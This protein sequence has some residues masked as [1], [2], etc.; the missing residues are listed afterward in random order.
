MERLL[1]ED[2]SV[3]AA[4]LGATTGDALGHQRLADAVTRHLDALPPASVLAL[5]GSWG[6][7]KSD[8]LGRVFACFDQRAK[9]FNTPQP[10]RLDPWQYGTPDLIRPVVLAL[11]NQ[12]SAEDWRGKEKLRIAARTLI[13]AGNAMLFKAL[14]VVVPTPVG[15]IIGAAEQ[16][17][18]DGLDALFSGEP[19]QRPVDPDPVKVMGERFHELV[20]IYV[21]R[22]D[23]RWPLLICVDDL[24][25]CLP[26]HQI[27]MLEAIFFLTA[28]G[29]DCSFLIAL[30][31]MLVQQAAVTHY[32]TAGFDANKY[33]DKL[34][35]LRLSL[36]ELGESSVQTL[37][38]HELARRTP[39]VRAASTNAARSME[40]LL[41]EGLNV[42]PEQ[43]AQI[44][45]EV[46]SLPELKNPRLIHRVCERIRL[47]AL[48]NLEARDRRAIGAARLRALVT[49]CAIADRWP[50][51]RQLLQDTRPDMWTDNMKI[52]CFTYGF[53]DVFGNSL[54]TAEIEDE[55]KKRSNIPDRLPGRLRQP[56][57]GEFLHGLVLDRPGL[58]D[59]LVEVDDAMIRFGL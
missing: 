51:L 24:D 10:V 4:N 14:T 13:R 33:L 32:R 39:P 43:T 29:A 18:A 25:R 28:A 23:R 55:L 12:I 44:F 56:D 2:K 46:F 49:W 8:V 53:T 47:L 38:Q 15:E 31:P 22:C 37:L 20:E 35:D 5:Q 50:D 1:G 11:L 52:V 36:P 41:R 3:D 7:G 54:T 59:E 48:A 16:P 58:V 40:S 17:V 57:L 45:S 21:G 19:T 27:A 30:D 9:E 6:R 42:T 34:F 26:D